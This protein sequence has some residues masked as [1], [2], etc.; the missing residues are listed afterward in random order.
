MMYSQT[1]DM[2]MGRHEMTNLTWPVKKPRIKNS[3]NS[4]FG[5]IV[6]QPRSSIDLGFGNTYTNDTGLDGKIVF[7]R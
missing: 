4:V 7:T 2:K 3:R 5:A 1:Y 6:V